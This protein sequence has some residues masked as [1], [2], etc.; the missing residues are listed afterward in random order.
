[1]SNNNIQKSLLFLKIIEKSTFTNR[2]IQIIYNILN[3]ESR[4][5]EISSGAYY[6]EVKQCKAKIRRLYYSLILLGLMGIINNE[7]LITLNL[8]V[9]RIYKLKDNNQDIHHDV[10]INPVI[11]IIEQ[12]LDKMIIL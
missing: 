8:V 7:Q 11:N 12:V 1:M 2:Q 9:E 5:K 4:P 3:K 10:S 6:R